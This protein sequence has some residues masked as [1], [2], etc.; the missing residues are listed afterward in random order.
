M[1]TDEEINA[2]FAAQD[3]A[4]KEAAPA[5]AASVIDESKIAAGIVAGLR[6]MQLERDAAMRA[7]QS[8]QLPPEEQEL[9]ITDDDT[10]ASAARKATHNATI[11]F[12]REMALM[13]NQFNTVGMGTLEQVSRTAVLD[14]DPTYKKYK[15]EVDARLS[16]LDPATRANPNVLKEVV[17][18][19]RADHV[20]DIAQE[21][22]Q[23]AIAAALK[24]G[25][26]SQPGGAS[27]RTYRP[28]PKDVPTPEELGFNEDQ[29]NMIN[30]SGGLDNFAQ[31]VSLGRFSNWEEY[32]KSFKKHQDARRA[33]KSGTPGAFMPLH[34]AGKK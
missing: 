14:N 30:R 21:I 34:K 20:E 6:D 23:R 8:N 2:Q 1:P 19:V 3:E 9:P 29:I 13:R 22:A 5:P 24:S 28:T 15:S 11:K 17:K 32:T 7:Q 16:T 27:G 26:G 31:K 10:P 18:M 33:N 25:E 12:N 4:P